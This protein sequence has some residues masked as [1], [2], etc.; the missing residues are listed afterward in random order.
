MRAFCSCSTKCMSH[1]PSLVTR[2]KSAS[3]LADDSRDI[4]TH[5]SVSELSQVFD[6]PSLLSAASQEIQICLVSALCR[7]GL[8]EVRDW[9]ARD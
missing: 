8:E 3:V 4:Q 5:I 1:E 7:Q 6:L 9:L 2:M